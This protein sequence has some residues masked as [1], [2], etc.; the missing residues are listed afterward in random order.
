MAAK[1][2]NLLSAFGK[3][4]QIF[5][6]I[7]DAV[8]DIGGDDEDITRILTDEDLRN[9][10]AHRI[11]LAK[12]S[13]KRASVVDEAVAR[14]QQQ[15]QKERAPNE[16]FRSRVGLAIEEFIAFVRSKEGKK[17]LKLLRMTDRAITVVEE[18]VPR[19]EQSYSQ[20]LYH[21]IYFEGL[22]MITV[23]Q[24]DSRDHDLTVSF[25]PSDPQRRTYHLENT[26]ELTRMVTGFCEERFIGNEKVKRNPEE[27][28]PH[29]KKEIEKIAT[30]IA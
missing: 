18:I 22:D 7:V 19:T 17:S 8:K 2:S 28:V 21:R 12:E 24:N 4:F 5:K 20:R 26:T 23:P 13:A 29:I 11:M 3:A 9:D 6:A 15:Q 30:A 1:K 10:I 16:E 27:F 14:L 25:P